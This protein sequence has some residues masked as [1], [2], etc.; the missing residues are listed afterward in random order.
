MANAIHLQATLDAVLANPKHWR[1]ASWHCGTSHCFAGFAEMVRLAENPTE[2]CSEACYGQGDPMDGQ[3]RAPLADREATQAWL[4]LTDEEWGRVVDGGNSLE[5]LK[6]I[7]CRLVQEH[8]QE[9][10][11]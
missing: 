9:T 6:R 10:P 2:M 4:G 3:R 7:V 8:S 5:D 1:Q 11:E